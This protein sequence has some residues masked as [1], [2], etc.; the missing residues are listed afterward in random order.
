MSKSAK[1]VLAGGLK[2]DWVGFLLIATT[3]GCVEVVLDRGRI[4]DW[5]QSANIV[6]FALIASVSFL[7]FIPWELTRK[8]EPMVELQL[9]FHRQFG[10]SFFV[11]LM[12]GVIL[13]SSNQIMPQL[14]QTSFQYTAMLSG[15]A[16]MPG[17]IAMLLLMPMVGQATG[18][19]EPKYLM[20]LGLTMIAL[21]M[22][23]S[24]SLVPYASIG[25]FAWLRVFQMAGLPF[26][27]IPIST[28]GYDGL[29]PD[30]TNQASSLINVARNLG[31]SVGISL[32]NAELAR[33][34]QFHQARLIKNAVP[35]LPRFQ[36]TL[37]KMTQYFM[38]QG[39][40]Q[41]DAHRRAMGLIGK[42]IEQQATILAYI[43]VF[44]L[45]AIV[46]IVMIPIVLILVGRVQS[47]R[48][49]APAH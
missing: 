37:D 47:G 20:T 15:F 46:A 21:S 25:Y 6:C 16:L 26:L 23:Y 1:V 48:R 43:D 41:S 11:M 13:Y 5:F 8:S 24:T 33:R 12:I 38:H 42:L 30:K 40:A 28:V 36:S 27:F 45:G 34:S 29:P 3:L 19:I 14:L 35:S 32:A 39:S 17:G 4:D 18:H 2:V 22:W 31:G 10:T 7:F 44:Y 49:A 9:L